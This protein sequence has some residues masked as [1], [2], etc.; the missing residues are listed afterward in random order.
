[1]KTPLLFATL[2]LTT[3]TT[4]AFAQV[5]VPPGGSIFNPPPPPPPPPPSMAVPVVP[6][7]DAPPRYNYR[8]PA[9]PSFG[10][11]VRRCLDDAAAAGMNPGDRATYS[12]MCANQ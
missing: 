10:D 9:R 6:K 11:R 2:L 3:L 5:L 8:P 4:G 7:L 1:M 12:R